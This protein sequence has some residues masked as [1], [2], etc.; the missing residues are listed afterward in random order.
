MFEQ[1]SNTKDSTIIIN[2]KVVVAVNNP[3]RLASFWIVIMSLLDNF[4][5]VNKKHTRVLLLLFFV[6]KFWT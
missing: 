3:V 6:N 1:H 4:N 5:Y 2:D